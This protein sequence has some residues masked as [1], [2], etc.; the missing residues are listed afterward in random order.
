MA[1][2]SY[3]AVNARL[4]AVSGTVV[5]DTPRQARDQL[6]ERGLTVQHVT[7]SI[8]APVQNKWIRSGTSTH[9]VTTIVRELST[10]LGAGIPLLDSID[11]VAEQY[12]GR[13]REVLLLLRERVAAGVSLAG[14]MEEQPNVFDDVCIHITEV[15]ESSGTLELVLERLAEFRE[16]SGQLRNRLG[17]ALLY[18][19]IVLSMGVGVSLFLMSYV[20]PELLSTLIAAGRP[21]PLATTMVKAVSDFLIQRW[22][23]LMIATCLSFVGSSA[24]MS[25]SYGKW[26]WHRLQLRLPLVGEMIR[27]QAVVRIAVVISTLTR[28]GVEFVRAVQI[29]QRSTKN[30]VLRQ[31]LVEFEVA[32]NAGRDLSTAL[33]ATQV[34]PRTVVQ[35]LSVG[36][37]SGR[38]EEMLDRLAMDYDRQLA[39][40]AARLTA[41]IEP[42]LILFLAV[43]VGFIAFAVML[44]ILEAGNAV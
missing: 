3:Q 40:A 16:R 11:S 24:A 12:H 26:R 7:Q 21:L 31:A 25:T 10:L 42:L 5:A 13:F 18:P 8:A 19:L 37:E 20:V 36:Q 23:L 43:I 1:V 4:A 35:I 28:G 9:K 39:T 2:F 22:W 30:L 15:G 6:R 34:F 33:A 27:K 41:V 32:V 29:A 44:P 14:A 38:L 17:T